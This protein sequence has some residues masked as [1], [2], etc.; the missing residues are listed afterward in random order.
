MPHEKKNQPC[1][2]YSL[3]E[4]QDK[5]DAFWTDITTKRQIYLKMRKF[6]GWIQYL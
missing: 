4:S 5:R 6:I 2:N 1:Q 3:R